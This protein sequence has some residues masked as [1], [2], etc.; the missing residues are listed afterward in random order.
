[1]AVIVLLVWVLSDVTNV[2][3]WGGVAVTELT[4][5]LIMEL[6]TAMRCYAF[7]RV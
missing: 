4:A 6:N 7:V 1:M 2:N 3:L 5:Y